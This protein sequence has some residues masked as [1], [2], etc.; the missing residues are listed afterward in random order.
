MGV[1]RGD[2]WGHTWRAERSSGT[3]Y[4]ALSFLLSPPTPF[5]LLCSLTS[6]PYPVPLDQGQ[7]PRLAGFSRDGKLRPASGS[8]HEPTRSLCSTLFTNSPRF[9]GRARL[10]P[11]GTSSLT[12]RQDIRP[13]TTG[14]RQEGEGRM[15]M[16]ARPQVPWAEGQ[17]PRMCEGL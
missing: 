6:P 5:S 9:P 1:R 14:G 12:R 8:L 4:L 11:S 16:P 7:G 15:E 10:P 3:A 2:H 13:E 17:G